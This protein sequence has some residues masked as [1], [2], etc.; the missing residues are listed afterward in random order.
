[1]KKSN[2]ATALATLALAGCSFLPSAPYAQ[3]AQAQPGLLETV[4][5]AADRLAADLLSR[6]A[7]GPVVVA[8]AQ[9][10]DALGQVCPQGRLVSDIVS[11]RLTQR[12]VKVTEVR[13][14]HSLRVNA[15][16]EQ[17]LSRNIDEL[18]GAAQTGV[19]VTATWTTLQPHGAWVVSDARGAASQQLRGSG[20][21]YL[22]LKAVRLDDSQVLSSQTFLAGAT[23]SCR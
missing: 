19:A 7:S 12:G 9:N 23:W 6:G 17:L 8:S 10:N 22:T 20:P 4:T 1:M 13:L 5:P 3:Q 2:L 21:T 14:A 16:G 18:A 11:S 15:E